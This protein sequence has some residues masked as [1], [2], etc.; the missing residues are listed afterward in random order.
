MNIEG[1]EYGENDNVIQFRKKIW[2]GRSIYGKD[3]KACKI[4]EFKLRI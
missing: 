1:K 3:P 2:L 4:K